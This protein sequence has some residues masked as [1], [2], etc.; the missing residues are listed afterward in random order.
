M[1]TPIG[2]AGRV[3][4][5]TRSAAP[6]MLWETYRRSWDSA[7][8]EYPIYASRNLKR[9]YIGARVGADTIAVIGAKDMNRS[10]ASVLGVMREPNML[11]PLIAL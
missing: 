5:E 2:K 8:T 11:R 4:G 3:H 6:K 7:A 10:L 1:V 9:D